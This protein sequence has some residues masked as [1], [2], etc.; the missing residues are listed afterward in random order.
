MRFTAAFIVLFL[1]SS[2]TLGQKNR[3][4]KR[5]PAKKP[6][7]STPSPTPTDPAAATAEFERISSLPIAA[8]RI[9]AL[10]QFRVAFWDAGELGPANELLAASRA[11]RGDELLQN[12]DL[13]NAVAIFRKSIDEAAL[14]IPGRLFTEVISK[15]PLRLF[16][17]GHRAPASELARLIEIK[18]ASNAGQMVELATYY[19]AIENGDD[20]R[21][22]SEKAIAFDPSAAGG[23]HS[24]GLAH[25]LNFNLE[26]STAAYSKSLEL[27]PSSNI[28]RRNLAEMKRALGKPDEA[29]SLYKEILAVE[30]ANLPAQTGLV[31]S[32]FDAEKRVEAE[33]EMS[34]SLK[35]NPNNV[36]LLA[37]A[38]YWYAAKNDGDRAIELAEKAIVIEPR[39]IWSHIALARGQ[40]ARHAPLEA[41]RVLISAR[42]YGNFP[43]LDYEIASARLMAGFYREAVDGLRESFSIRD[44]VIKTRLGVRIPAEGTSFTDLIAGERKASIFEPTAADDPESAR[45]LRSLLEFTGILESTDPDADA[46]TFAVDDFVR[47]GDAMKLHRQLFAANALLERSQ[48]LPTVLE[49]TSNAIGGAAAALEV[50]NP[51]S[52]VMASE[53]YA[54]R[55]AAF[56]SGEILQ[57]PEVPKNT[58]S[59]ILRGRIEE[60]TGWALYQ[61]NDPAAAVIRLKRA[62]SVLPENSAWWR[63]SVWRLGAAL[64]ADGKHSEGL[65]HFIKSYKADKPD[66]IKYAIIE[67]LYSRVH[68]STDGLASAIGSE[69][70]QIAGVST[71]TRQ[72]EPSPT[73]PVLPPEIPAVSFAD[74]E[75]LAAAP[76]IPAAEATLI[77]APQYPSIAE[78]VPTDSAPNLPQPDESRR[79]RIAPQDIKDAR[80][81]DPSGDPATV[82][83]LS[84]AAQVAEEPAAVPTPEASPAFVPE[85]V[86]EQASEPVASQVVPAAEEPAAVPTPESMVQEQASVPLIV[87]PV[88]QPVQ[89]AEKP[90]AVSTPESMVQERAADPLIVDPLSQAAQ[91]AE[92]PAPVP[93]PVGTP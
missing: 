2:I 70:V 42:K 23:Y 19:L 90:A 48:A 75:S 43:T 8:D 44:W 66:V 93:T 71:P 53:L 83:P 91:P 68:G 14:P 51:N 37:G 67:A 60:I 88:S 79:E 5:V 45:Q 56:A 11:V 35:S 28:V 32:L 86:E 64:D 49:L 41:E 69:P 46:L 10:E 73:T 3:R 65:E 87:D 92:D 82:D 50:P 76:T 22:L 17:A 61:Q 58:L 52:A 33:T 63:S 59:A 34:A 55:R 36:I 18:V 7:A 57:V 74:T 12:G 30:P 16:Y 38:A 31:L 89:V 47:G 6:V 84:Q 21:R 77:E 27:D 29:A 25:R 1:F 13:T 81:K 39:Y 40:M 62:V 15:I 54:S 24:L 20:A 85:I 80:L 26:A 72:A 9:A 78:A 4:G